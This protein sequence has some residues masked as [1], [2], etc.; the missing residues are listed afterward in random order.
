MSDI[1]TPYGTL[2]ETELSARAR[3]VLAQE[4]RPLEAA[5]RGFLPGLAAAEA[6]SVLVALSGPAS[7]PFAET[8]R[9]SLGKLPEAVVESALEAQLSAPL[10]A[11]LAA[12]H[13]RNPR[14]LELLLRQVALPGGSLTTLARDADET[15]GEIIATNEV[16]LLACPEAI[17]RLYMNPKVRMGTA[18][19]LVEL[20]VRNGVRLALPAYDEVVEAL[21]EELIPAPTAEPQ[22]GD[23]LFQ[24]VD[25]LARAT[26]SDED[27]H[28]VSEEGEEQLKPRFVPLYARILEMSV[29]EKIRRATLGTSSER[30]LLVRDMNRL[31]ASAAARSPLLREPDAVRIGASKQVHVDV[32]RILATSKEFARSYALKLTLVGNPRTPFTF[33][34]RIVPYLRE[35]DLRVLAKSKNVTSNI[36][37]AARQQL[38]RKQS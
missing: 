33:A 37:R 18:N 23:L 32:L 19:R 22:A 14:L 20:A 6:V 27:T 26:D 10:V 28:E 8:A 24:E 2:A 15:L 5:A 25:A 9:Q 4:G 31:V 35:S 12:A 34:S 1:E 21:R 30:M 16:K 7:G 29:T 36:Q 13:G 11:A 3:R 38:G 17:E